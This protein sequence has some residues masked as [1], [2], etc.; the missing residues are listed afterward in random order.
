MVRIDFGLSG[1]DVRG[2]VLMEKMLYL[3]IKSNNECQDL[4]TYREIDVCEAC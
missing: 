2:Q 4:M 1:L 3:V